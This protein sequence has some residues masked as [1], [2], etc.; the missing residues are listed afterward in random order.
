M[1]MNQHVW[2][3]RLSAGWDWVQILL[4]LNFSG[5]TVD[6]SD[7]RAIVLQRLSVTDKTCQQLGMQHMSTAIGWSD[8][9][10]SAFVSYNKPRVALELELPCKCF[11]IQESVYVLDVSCQNTGPIK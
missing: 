6:V 5:S 11:K 1:I 8:A 10:K 7:Y 4:K 3:E 2:H 9:C